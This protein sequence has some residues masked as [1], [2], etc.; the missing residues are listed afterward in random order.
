MILVRSIW[1][2]KIWR[3]TLEI[4]RFKKSVSLSSL[5]KTITNS[6]RL[7]CKV[8]DSYISGRYLRKQL[9][10]RPHLVITR[11]VGWRTVC[12]PSLGLRNSTLTCQHQR[13]LNLQQPN[14]KNLILALLRKMS[15]VGMMTVRTMMISTTWRSLSG[16]WK[17]RRRIWSGSQRIRMRQRPKS[18]LKSRNKEIKKFMIRSICSSITGR[19]LLICLRW[20]SGGHFCRMTYLVSL[21]KLY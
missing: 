12:K 16:K 6:F 20:S 19:G 10:V 11:E 17:E 4:W 1:S 13:I 2:S 9:M 21:A 18:T 5:R 15:M 14:Q 8:V 3:S 7:F